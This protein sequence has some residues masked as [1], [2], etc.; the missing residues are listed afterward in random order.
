MIRPSSCIQ[1]NSLFLKLLIK[2]IHITGEPLSNFWFILLIITNHVIN[3]LSL[4]S[5]LLDLFILFFEDF[6]AE[7]VVLV[8]DLGPCV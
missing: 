1:H 2:N 6:D 8:M 5:Q 4:L 3:E 7:I